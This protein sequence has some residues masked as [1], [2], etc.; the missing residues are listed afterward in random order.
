MKRFKLHDQPVA[1]SGSRSG[2]AA[3]EFAVCLPILLILLIGTIEACTMIYLKQTL[4]VAAYEGIRAAVAPNSTTASVNAAC[5]RILESRNVQNASVTISPGNYSNE[6]AETW[7]TV[8]VTAPGRDNSII[9]GWFYDDH[10][11]AAE[12]TMMKEF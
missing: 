4:S 6:P 8:R 1:E 3:T 2:V 11:I 5:N 10:E 9:P 12:A 7:L